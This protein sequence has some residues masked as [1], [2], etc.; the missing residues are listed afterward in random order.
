MKM[1]KYWMKSSFFMQSWSAR[2]CSPSPGQ[3]SRERLG[4][5][6]AMTARCVE[7][8]D[9]ALHAH[10]IMLVSLRALAARPLSTSVIVEVRKR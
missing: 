10:A 5:P 2:Q 4:A 8:L 9:R 3:Q 7:H 6:R 1:A